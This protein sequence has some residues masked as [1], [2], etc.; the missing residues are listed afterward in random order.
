MELGRQIISNDRT[1]RSDAVQDLKEFIL[2]SLST[3]AEKKRT[4]GFN[5]ARY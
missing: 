4:A 1:V 5:D 3:R 2:Q